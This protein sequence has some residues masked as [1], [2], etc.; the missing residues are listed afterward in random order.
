MA[1]VTVVNDNDDFLDLMGDILRQQGHDPAVV[2]AA[3]V[4]VDDLAATEPDVLVVDLRLDD[5]G[6]LSD[7]WSVVVGARAHPELAAVPIVICTADRAEL[8][9]HASEIAALADVHR[10]DKPFQLDDVEALLAALLDRGNHG[11]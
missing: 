4:T 8:G 11:G 1:R 9:R 6:L 3:T 7:G 10:L 2:R 5:P